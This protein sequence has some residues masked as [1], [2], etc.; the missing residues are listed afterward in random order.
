MQTLL[1]GSESKGTKSVYHTPFF[2]FTKGVSQQ[3]SLSQ[4]IS[5]GLQN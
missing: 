3:S 1:Q 4:G 2:P 5:Q